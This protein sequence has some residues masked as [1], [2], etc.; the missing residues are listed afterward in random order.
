MRRASEYAGRVKRFFTKLKRERGKASLVSTEDAT[1]WML[2]GILS[3]YASESRAEAALDR[4]MSE[5]VDYNDL[6]VT[7]VADIVEIVGVDYP[8][9]RRAAEQI[10]QVLNS[11]FNRTHD[12]D[13][14]FLRSLSKKSARSFLASLDGLE[15]HAE[16]FFAKRFLNIHAVPLDANM[17]LCLRRDACLP[18]DAESREAH[19]LVAGAI[20]ERDGLRFYALFKR[21][22]AAHTSR[23]PARKVA[24]SAAKKAGAAATGRSVVKKKATKPVRK[25]SAKK[26]TGAAV[27]RASKSKKAS[28]PRR[29]PARHR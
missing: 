2:L 19:K 18:D 23:R 9:C 12:L 8:K 21:Y 15:P 7:P 1:R 16:A 5:M 26:K 4:L 13:L 3:N 14:S 10:S 24:A 20:S 25:E 29:A 6:R 17:L 28:K 22:A 27:S 11:L